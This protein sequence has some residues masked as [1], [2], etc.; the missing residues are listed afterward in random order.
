MISVALRMQH[1]AGAGWGHDQAQGE[2][3]TAQQEARGT[4]QGGGLLPDPKEDANRVIEDILAV[5]RL[6]T[7]RPASCHAP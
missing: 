4:P 7:Q 6:P 5:S 3:S 2:R 1:Q